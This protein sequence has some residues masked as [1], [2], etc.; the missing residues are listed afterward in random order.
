MHVCVVKMS[1]C[2]HGLISCQYADGLDRTWEG[3]VLQI[4]I[5]IGRFVFVLSP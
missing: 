2:T 5:E 4:D 1:L 3:C